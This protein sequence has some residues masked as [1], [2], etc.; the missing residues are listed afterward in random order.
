MCPLADADCRN[1]FCDCCRGR[2]GGARLSCLDCVIKGTESHDTVDLCC[3]EECVAASLMRDDLEAPHDPN[4][5]LVKCRT[6]VLTRQRG[7]AFTAAEEAFTKVEKFCK[8]IAEAS[9]QPPEKQEAVPDAEAVSSPEDV[10]SETPP[11]DDDKQPENGTAASVDASSGAEGVEDRPQE[12]EKETAQSAEQAQ[13]PD[14]DND[15]PS[16]G[17]CDG[18]LSFPCWYCVKCEGKLSLDALRILCA[19]PDTFLPDDLFLCEACEASDPTLELMRSSGKH[20]E[21]HNLIRCQAPKQEDCTTFST[22]DRLMSLEDRLNNMTTRIETMEQLL[23][24]VANAVESW[25]GR[26]EP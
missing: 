5:R 19:V 10:P 22:E 15:L 6:T 2:I 24:Q 21:D 20:G 1:A 12:Q 25:H 9:Q 13:A 16:C 23:R 17:K 26:R 4:H 14:Q 18:P 7:R 8:K 11:K 3:T